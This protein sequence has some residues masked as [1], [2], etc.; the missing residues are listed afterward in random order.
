MR[1]K[2]DKRKISCKVN[3]LL[4][5]L[6]VR[7]VQHKIIIVKLIIIVLRLYGECMIITG[8]LA[9]RIVNR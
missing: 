6:F 1:R 3:C 2:S 4:L 7:N 8:R 5:Y 9:E